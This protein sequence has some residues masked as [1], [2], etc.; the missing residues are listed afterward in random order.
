[1]PA[2]APLVRVHANPYPT[3]SA[4]VQ[5]NLTARNLTCFN[6]GKGISYTENFCPKDPSNVMCC[7]ENKCNAAGKDGMCRS[8][9]QGCPGGNFADGGLCPGGGDAACCVPDPGM[10]QTIPQKILAQAETAA[11]LPY[12]WGGGSCDGPTADSPPW[13]YGDIGFDCS[14]LVCWAVCK[15]TGRDLFSE[16]LR[17]TRAMYCADEA[18]LK[19]KKVPFAERQAGDAIFFGGACDCG[20]SE[21]IHHVGLMM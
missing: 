8:K 11:G 16:G 1:M 12:A 17:N 4:Q 14:G 19:Y 10:T 21:S 18:K 7:V 15:V 20:S 13:Q 2:T 6:L 3:V 5:N 9:A